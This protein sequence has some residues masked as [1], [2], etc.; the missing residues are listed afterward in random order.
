MARAV[1]ASGTAAA[2]PG[3]G[4]VCTFRYSWRL[5]RTLVSVL[6]PR[7]RGGVL[8]SE[9]LIWRGGCQG[10]GSGFSLV[11]VLV[12]G[13]WGAFSGRHELK[14]LSHRRG[15]RLICEGWLPQDPVFVAARCL[16]TGAVGRLTAHSCFAGLSATIL[17][18][19]GVSC[20]PRQRPGRDHRRGRVSQGWRPPRGSWRARVRRRSRR[21]RRVCV[22]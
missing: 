10:G 17:G 8:R 4:R 18:L 11:R 20:T 9:Q 21:R 1:V 13:A 22:V 2:T 3:V 15:V 12:V 7:S 14:V 6:P 16:L 5:S 19:R